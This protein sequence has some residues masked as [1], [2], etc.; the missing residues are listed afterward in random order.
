MRIELVI[1]WAAGYTVGTLVTIAI[2]A[3]YWPA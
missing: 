2:F 3:H 1:G